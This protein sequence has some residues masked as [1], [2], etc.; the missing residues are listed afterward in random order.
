MNAA[1]L[2]GKVKNIGKQYEFSDDA[3]SVKLRDGKIVYVEDVTAAVQWAKEELA[4]QHLTWHKP[5]NVYDVVNKVLDQ[6][7]ET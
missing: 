4:R 6:A 3:S 1:P 5:I 2:R 7:F